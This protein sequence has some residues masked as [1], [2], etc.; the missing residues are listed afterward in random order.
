[1]YIALGAM[2]MMLTACGKGG[3]DLS[4][5]TDND[6]LE[7]ELCHPD[8]KVCVQLCTTNVDCPASAKT[9]AA[10]NDNGQK[11]CQCLSQ[12]CTNP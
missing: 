12:Q 3:A 2:G 6:C 5:A 11:I 4:C 8:K 9:C 10:M 7:S 1:M